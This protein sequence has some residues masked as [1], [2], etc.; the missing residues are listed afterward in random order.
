MDS[1]VTGALADEA[2]IGV[3]RDSGRPS[4]R[5][6]DRRRG[7]DPGHDGGGAKRLRRAFGLGHG[8]PAIVT[9]HGP[10]AMRP[11]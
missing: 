9:Y 1:A 6:D 3:D 10:E 11:A 5:G 7:R 2:S 4:R 8:L